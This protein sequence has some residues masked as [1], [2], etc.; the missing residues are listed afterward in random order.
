MKSVRQLGCVS[1]DAEPPESVTI[2]R[3]GT[4]VWDQFDE[5]DKTRGALRQANILDNKGPSLG[6]KQV[7]SCHQ[8]SP[9]AV[10]FEDRSQEETERTRAMSPRR[11]VET[12]QK[13]LLAHRNGKKNYILFAFR[14]VGFAG[15]I[16][17]K[18]GG[19]RFCGG[20][21]SK[22]AHGQQYRPSLCRIGD[23][24][25]IEKSNDGDDGQRRGANKRRATLYVREL[26]LSVTVMLLEDTPAVPSLGKLC[27][28]HGYNYHWTSG[29]IPHLIKK[30][31]KYQLQHSELRTHRC[32]WSIDKLFNRIFP[33]LL[34]LHLRRRKPWLPRSIQQQQEVRVVVKK[35]RETCRMDHQK[36]RTQI[37]MTTTRKYDCQKFRH[38]LVDGCVPVH[39]DASSS[40]HELPSEPRAK[41]VSGKHSGFSHFPKDRHCDICLRT[42]ITCASCRK[43]TG[44]VLPR[45]ESFGDFITED[46]KVLSEGCESRNN[47]R[48]AVVVQHLAT[49]WNQSYPCKTKTSQETQK[50]LQKFLELTRKPKTFTLKIP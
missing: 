6:K 21:R 40:S 48:Y 32:P 47:H 46:H 11:R 42:K 36:P 1:Q 13:H 3:K 24:E 50:S 30:L 44:T 17:N 7:K 37:K 34:L 12:C 29:Q 39:W 41:V 2:S 31:Q 28:D 16:H 5:Y 14:W 8:R 27:E 10:K 33:H 20:P 22:H 38:G 23:H 26:D 45:A 35:Y 18:A 4:K 9:Y 15:R 25:D 43:C 49:R 19:K